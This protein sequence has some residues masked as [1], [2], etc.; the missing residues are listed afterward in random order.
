MY[1]E[2]RGIAASAESGADILIN[3]IAAAVAYLLVAH[4]YGT[5][6]AVTDGGSLLFILLLLVF[7]S[8]YYRLMGVYEPIP[9]YAEN[10]LLSRIVFAEVISLPIILTVEAF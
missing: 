10:R 6:I 8:V 9:R 7:L 4:L 5:V 2:K 3:A 1:K